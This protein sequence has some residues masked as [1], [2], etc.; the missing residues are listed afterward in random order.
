MHA[1]LHDEARRLGWDGTGS[2]VY[3]LSREIARLKAP[4]QE[5]DPRVAR[6]TAAIKAVCDWRWEAS[7][8]TRRMHAR[9][10]HERDHDPT[11]TFADCREAAFR[12]F[13]CLVLNSDG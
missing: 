2:P 9:Y 4:L 7:D 10:I 12:W 13:I 3:W 1:D 5:S 8:D 6:I 11:A